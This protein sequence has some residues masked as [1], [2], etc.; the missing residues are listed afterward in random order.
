MRALSLYRALSRRRRR[1]RR[2]RRARRYGCS[3]DRRLGVSGEDLPG[4]YSARD[5]VNWYNGHPDAL[6]LDPLLQAGPDAVIFG[7]GNVALDVA[8]VLLAPIDHLAQTD[9]AAHALAA[10]AE[11][12][13]ERVHVV[14][15]RG[16]I[17]VAFTIKEL[18]ELTKLDGCT[19]T[20]DP[21]AVAFSPEEREFIA[22]DRRK[23]RLVGLMETIANTTPNSETDERGGGGGGTKLV[24]HRTP[25]AVHGAATVEGVELEVNALE[26]PLDARLAVGTG[27]R[28]TLGCG[29]VFRSIGY[30]AVPVDPSLPFDHQ[31]GVIPN[32]EGR[33]ES[34][35]GLYC[36]GWIKT[37][38]TG[39]IATTMANAYQT[40][41][42]IAADLA[43]GILPKG[44]LPSSENPR[45]FYSELG[46]LVVT[47][48]GWKAIEAGEIAAGVR[49]NKVAEKETSI[50]AMLSTA[51]AASEGVLQK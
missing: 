43:A 1:R 7:Q 14:G 23:K 40:A 2:R 9:I 42:S 31:R 45:D 26:G 29:A 27:V 24:F 22:G 10:L 49:K 48:E 15:R 25:V 47:F 3:E 11:S 13:I 39:V 35:P 5:F 16:P 18:R 30:K 32:T 46:P 36:A 44:G 19:P 6:G 21:A 33:V 17:D 4:V 28:E 12:T 34:T 20:I 41:R 8:R 38:P 51:A 50:E 37:G